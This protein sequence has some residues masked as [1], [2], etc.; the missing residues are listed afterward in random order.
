MTHLESRS[1]DAVAVAPDTGPV[2]KLVSLPEPV[3]APGELLVEGL[4]VG[5]CGTDR[6]VIEGASSLPGRLVLGHE[7]LGRVVDAPSGSPVSAGDLV[8][9]LIRRPCPEHCASCRRNEL[10]RCLTRPPVER[11]ISRADGFAAELWTSPPAYLCPVP[12]QLNE[13]GVLIEPASSIM[14]GLRRIS[15]PGRIGPP[16]NALVLGAGTMGALTAAALTRRGVDVDVS[17]PFAAGHRGLIEDL[18]ARLLE[19]PPKRRAY[20]V[21]VEASGA[22]VAFETC[23]DAAGPLGRVLVLGL[24]AAEARASVHVERLV[25]DDVEVT[26][27]VNATPADHRAAADL[28]CEIEPGVLGRLMQRELPLARYADALVA[29]GKSPKT[30]VRV[31]A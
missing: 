4:L 7:S 2:P 17:D 30:V 28:L 10:D 25:M 16:G 31:A 19:A 1:V 18:G 29:D 6:A 27:S 23:L 13:A 12:A 9:G 20:D 14:K 8:V 5:I 11:G 15:E 24:P 3:P 22:E 21:V 26:F